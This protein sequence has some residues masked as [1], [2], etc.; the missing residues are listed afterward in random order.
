MYENNKLLYLLRAYMWNQ[1]KC[2]FGW[3]EN[4]FF[5]TIHYRN[6][7]SNSS[8]IFFECNPNFSHPQFS[9]QLVPIVLRVF[10]WCFAILAMSIDKFSPVKRDFDFFLN[11]DRIIFSKK[12]E[13]KDL[14][15]SWLFSVLL[16]FCWCVF[17]IARIMYS[18]KKKLDPTNYANAA[19]FRLYNFFK[20]K[21]VR[22]YI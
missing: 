21:A 2:W 17:R 8:N 1:I 6:W 11:N 22:I 13:F 4:R 15:N 20:S 9:R 12:S 16:I 14:T 18:K 7:H 3:L 10:K 19:V 5:M